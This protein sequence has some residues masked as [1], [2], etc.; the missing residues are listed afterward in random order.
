MEDVQLVPTADLAAR[1]TR[2][3]PNESPEYREARNALLAEEIGLRR[4]IERVA[5]QRRSLPPGGEVTETYRFDGENG[6]ATLTELFGRHDSLAVY[7]YMFGPEHARPCP[8]CTSLLDAWAGKVGAITDRVALAI[9]ARS[10]I[11]KLVAWKRERGWPDMP[12]YSDADGAF[13]RAYV[14]AEDADVPGYTVFSRRD[15]AIRHFWSAEMSDEMCDPGQD[16]RGAPDLD[17][18]WTVLD[19]TPGGRGDWYP[20]LD[21]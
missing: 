4:A 6:P 13:T 21:Y 20:R 19:T 9:V 8:M 3:F 12:L 16:P 7:S 17:P 18:L 5:A 14:S 15:G 10:P 2:V 1:N 11:G